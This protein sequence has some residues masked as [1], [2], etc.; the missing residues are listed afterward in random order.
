[1]PEKPS[2]IY[3]IKVTLKDSKP[4]I[5]RR[6]LVPAN[7][8]LYKLHQIIQVAM[9]W[10]DYHLHQFVIY[11]QY[12]GDPED[13]VTGF[14]GTK[15][16][17]RFKLSAFATQ[18]GL[19]FDYQYDFGDG[20]EHTILIEKIA[21]PEKDV[22]YPHCIKG[23]RACPP[24]D[25]GGVWGYAEFLEAIRDPNHPEHD[26]Y[27]EWIGSEFDPT[28]FDLEEVNEMLAGM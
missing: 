26:E 2:P 1:M 21:S 25:V 12:Y 8:T 9:G 11:G 7:I 3:Q 20:W 16:E 19:K 28:E 10:G 13:D 23:R 15:N 24:E 14:M 6:L 18:E 4:P 5:W 27:L 17:Q 22:H